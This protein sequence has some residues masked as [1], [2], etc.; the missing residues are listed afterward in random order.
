LA[1]FCS[2][3]RVIELPK[4]LWAFVLQGVMLRIRPAR[5]AKIDQRVWQDSGSPLMVHLK[6]QSEALRHELSLRYGG[7]VVVDFAMRYGEP[8][9]ANKLSSMLERGV[10]KLVLLPLY[11]QYSAV[12]TGSTFDALAS[13]FS[14]RRWLPDLR[15][16][17]HYHDHP[18]YIDALVAS[19]KEHQAQHGKPDKLVFSYHGLPMSCL[20]QGDPYHCECHKTT[21]LVVERLGLSDKEY[22]TSFQS[23]VGPKE[24]LQPYTDETMKTLGASGVK[25]VQ[26]ICP[27]FSADCIETIDE[28]DDENRGYFIESGGKTFSYIPALNAQANHIKLILSLVESNLSGWDMYVPEA[29]A[30]A[31]EQYLLRAKSR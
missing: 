11:P 6:A 21:R 8:S 5:S 26:V 23:K 31:E 17:T 28:I 3:P 10:R 9:I 13:D 12:T 29:G 20:E 22:I 27:G 19:I 2:D 1:D 15:F 4:L 16:V 25:S 18:L 7:Q 30:Q 24:W 14:S